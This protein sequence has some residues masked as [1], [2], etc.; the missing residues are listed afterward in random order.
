MHS[1][2]VAFLSSALPP[3]T[4]VTATSGGRGKPSRN[5]AVDPETREWRF[6]PA[7]VWYDIL[8]VPEDGSQLNYGFKLKVWSVYLVGRCLTVSN[9]LYHRPQPLPPRQTMRGSPLH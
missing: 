2:Q 3:S 8:G 1:L 4:T 6:G 9:P 5:R 7:K